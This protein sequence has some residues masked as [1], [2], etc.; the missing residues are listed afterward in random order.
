MEINRM[1]NDERSD[2]L[3]LGEFLRQEGLEERQ[4]ISMRQ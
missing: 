1:D 4:N 3:Q 2:S